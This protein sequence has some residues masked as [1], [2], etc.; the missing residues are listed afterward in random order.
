MYLSENIRY[1]R[2]LNKLSQE[3]IAKELGYKSFT[4]IQKWE[5]GVADPPLDKLSRLAEIFKVD[6]DDLTH[7]PLFEG[8]PP[9]AKSGG[10]RIPVY[11]RL[12]GEPP[13]FPHANVVD[14]EELP[15]D[16]EQES[17]YF[18]LL[19][20]GDMMEP[21]LQQG[22]VVI[23]HRQT[24]IDSG[25]TVIVTIANNDAIC[26]RVQK[27]NT[28]LMLIPNNTKYETLFFSN[29]E[30]HALPVAIIGKVVELRGKF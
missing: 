10:I 4:T 6:I 25:D 7:L 18:G 20:E 3:R 9:K 27:T 23:V 17:N 5:S 22:D 26:M 8:T 12:G 1:L 15:I 21:R 24:E 13:M 29:D 28:G 30:V 2:K 19:I 11:A 14:Y 16:A